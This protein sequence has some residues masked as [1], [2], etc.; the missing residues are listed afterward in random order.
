MPLYH[1]S[2]MNEWQ[3]ACINSLGFNA[4]LAHNNCQRVSKQSTMDGTGQV[5]YYNIPQILILIW[6]QFL[7]FSC[8]NHR[9]WLIQTWYDWWVVGWLLPAGEVHSICQPW[10][11]ERDVMRISFRLP[12]LPWCFSYPQSPKHQNLLPS[13]KWKIFLSSTTTA[14]KTHLFHNFNESINSKNVIHLILE[15]LTLLKRYFFLPIE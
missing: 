2:S 13:C 10:V 12:T 1:A 3:K 8:L 9:N 6:V 15:T 14:R 7:Q 4:T 11:C 5:Y